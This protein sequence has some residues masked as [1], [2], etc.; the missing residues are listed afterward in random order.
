MTAIIYKPSQVLRAVRAKKLA[1][2]Q[3]RLAMKIVC[4]AKRHGTIGETESPTFW[5]NG[6][7]HYCEQCRKWVLSRIVGPGFE[8]DLT[9]ERKKYP[10]FRGDLS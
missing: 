9:G 10:L 3:P 1:D 7:Y 8:I 5:E 2:P 6:S 4:E